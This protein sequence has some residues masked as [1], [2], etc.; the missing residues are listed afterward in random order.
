MPQSF[1]NAVM[2]GRTF[3]TTLQDGIRLADVCAPKL[4]EAGGLDARKLLEDL[5]LN[6]YVVFEKVSMSFDQVVADVWV[7]GNSVNECMRQHGYN[8]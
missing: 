7:D 4:N 8:C 2:D 3:S 1:C 6:K 5:I